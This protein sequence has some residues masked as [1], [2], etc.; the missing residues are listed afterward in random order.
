MLFNK[1]RAMAYME[2]CGVDVLVATSPVNVTYF[3]GYY[4]W[5][6]PLFRE[7]MMAPGA[8]SEIPQK[9]SVFPL[10]GEPALVVGPDFA[11]NAADLWVRDLH[12]AGSPVVDT[13]LT[14]EALPEDDQRILD[15]LQSPHRNA[16]PT[17]ALLSILKGRGLT[18]ARIGMEMEGLAPSAK[19]EITKALP[20]AKIMDCSDMIRLI[21]MVKTEEELARLTRAAEISEEAGMES[22]ALARAGKTMAHVIQHYRGADRRGRRRSRSL[23]VRC[24][25][26]GVSPWSGIMC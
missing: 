14:P 25:R 12:I 3:S 16:K 24:E 7:Y 26:S 17:D 8:S 19:A 9:F 15:L 20:K 4:C 5:I 11:T 1:T 10:E 2:R 6:D 22:L 18:E 13:S 23:H 21:R